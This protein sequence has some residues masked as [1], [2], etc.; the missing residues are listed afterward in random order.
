MAEKSE[1]PI[2]LMPSTEGGK[3][4]KLMPTTS[5]PAGPTWA[6][7]VSNLFVPEKDLEAGQ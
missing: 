6:E 3:G 5:P 2:K 4:I 1:P 7:R